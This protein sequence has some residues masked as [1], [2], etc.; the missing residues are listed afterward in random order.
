M[1]A[2]A[3]YVPV[4]NSGQMTDSKRRQF[5]R[6]ATAASATTTVTAL[7]G[8]AGVLSEGS[9]NDQQT[10]VDYTLPEVTESAEVEMGPDGTNRFAPEI[11]SVEVGG[12]VTWTNVSANHSATAYAPATD[13]PRRIPEDADPWDTGVITKD[14]ASASHT[15]ETPGVYDYYCT[16]HEPFGMVASVVVGTPDSEGQPGLKPPG[17][18]RSGSAAA[19]LEALNAKFGP[20]LRGEFSVDE[21]VVVT[22]R[23][24]F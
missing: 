10:T 11:V 20:D 16:P 17:E 8:C 23:G 12:T 6:S 19:K 15:F 9:E 24:S 4:P 7:A 1:G 13:Y 18:G 21:F 3:I 14:G 22:K 2:Q 5:L